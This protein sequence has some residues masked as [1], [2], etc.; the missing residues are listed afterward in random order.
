MANSR[1]GH[2]I[3]NSSYGFISKLITVFLSF[4]ARTI[5]IKTLGTEYLG[6]E[7]LFSNILTML[8]LAEL[9]IGNVL[10]FSLYKPIANNENERINQLL[11]YYR[12]IYNMIAIVVAIIGAAIIPFLSYVVKSSFDSKTIIVFYLLYLANSVI[13]YIA[14]CYTTLIKAEQEQ[15]VIEIISTITK[16]VATVIQ[17]V[18]L[19]VDRNFILYLVVLVVSTLVQNLIASLYAKNTYGIKKVEYVI[20]EDERRILWSSIRSTFLYKIGVVIINYTD[21]ILIS[22]MIGTAF[23]GYYSNYVLIMTQFTMVINILCSALIASVGNM[24]VQNDKDKSYVVFKRLVF[25]FHFITCVCSVG[26]ILMFNEVITLWI[27][28]ENTLGFETVI[29]ITLSFYIQNII[30]PVWM[31]REAYGLFKEIKYLMLVTAALNIVLSIAGGK[32]LGLAGI[33]GATGISRCLTTV[34]YEPRILY[35]KA[36][37]RNVSEYFAMQIKYIVCT[38]ISL[39]LSFYLINSVIVFDGI[40]FTGIRCIVIVLI[41]SIIFGLLNLKT[42]EL[43][44]WIKLLKNRVLYKFHLQ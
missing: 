43:K 35:K 16:T 40:V 2:V 17:I 28:E 38:L 39:I 32:Y 8:S 11:S 19:I 24:S 3:K 36:F 12:R 7:G 41:C 44:Y 10:T 5:F 37:Q 25:F 15:Y 14:V 4:F 23:V 18:V 27:G 26:F 13:S 31:Y 21:N 22:V 30:N 20:R 6:V 29:A 33:I 42:E 9:G 1:T 34:W